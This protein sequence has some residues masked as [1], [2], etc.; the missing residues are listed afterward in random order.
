MALP[1]CHLLYQFIVKPLNTNERLDF[2]QPGRLTFDESE[3]RSEYLDALN[4]PKFYLDLNMYQRSVD[5]MLGCPFNLASM[6]LLLMIFAK[7]SNMIPGIATWIGGDTHLYLDHIELAK[8]QITRKPYEL[9]ELKI[10]KELNNLEDILAL[11]IDD[12]E[13][14]N[15]QSHPKIEAELF[16][17]LKK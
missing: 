7:V 4:V 12:F 1:P 3:E 14:L 13:L 17:G 6:S 9:P 8:E 16:T 10:N 11:T 5:V 15:Y 2:Y